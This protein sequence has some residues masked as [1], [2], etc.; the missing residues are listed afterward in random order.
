M[1]AVYV[2]EDEWRLRATFSSRLAANI[3]VARLINRGIGAKVFRTAEKL[4]R[5]A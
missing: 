1:Y 2:L 5:A 3:L 4:T